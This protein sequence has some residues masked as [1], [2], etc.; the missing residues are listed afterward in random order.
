MA[1]ES[2]RLICCLIVWIWANSSGVNFV[3]SRAALFWL[4][5]T[6]ILFWP[7][8]AGVLL[9]LMGLFVVSVNIFD[10][11]LHNGSTGHR[12]GLIDALGNSIH[13][14]DLCIVLHTD[15]PCT[16]AMFF[17]GYLLDLFILQGFEQGLSFFI[18][19]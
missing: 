16:E 11:L 1:W 17:P 19:D 13:L 8:G 4:R 7:S 3:R 9:S 5:G 6:G 12:H 18:E 15:K 14:D 10:D 2:S